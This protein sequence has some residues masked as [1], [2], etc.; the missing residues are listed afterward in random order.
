MP[1]SHST[2]RNRIEVGCAHGLA[3]EID[4]TRR[5]AGGDY[6]LVVRVTVLVSLH[7]VSQVKTAEIVGEE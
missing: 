4:K 7:L 3:C 2:G 6:P 5:A 1:T